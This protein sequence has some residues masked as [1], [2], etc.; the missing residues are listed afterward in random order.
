MFLTLPTREKT[1]VPA[2]LVLPVSVNQAGPFGHDGRDVVPGLD[3]VDV[4]G[5]APQALL[6]GKRRA[7]A[8]ASG[9]AFER[10]DQRRLFAADERARAFHQFDI[11]VEA[12]AQD[13]VAQQ[14][15]FAGLLD[16]AFAGDGR[17]ADIRRARR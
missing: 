14:A 13:V 17:P 3:V 7:R 12:A 15:V 8:G 6:R 10:G 2:L 16:G 5:H 1:L 11:E 9:E 4:G